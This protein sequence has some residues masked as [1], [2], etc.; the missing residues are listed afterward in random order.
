M[1]LFIRKDRWTTKTLSRIKQLQIWNPNQ[2]RRNYKPLKIAFRYFMEKLR[3]IQIAKKFRTFMEMGGWW[4]CK[5]GSQWLLRMSDVHPVHITTR[6]LRFNLTS[7]TNVRLGLLR[8]LFRSGFHAESL[9]A[10]L[11]AP[12]CST[13][14]AH[15]ILRDSIIPIIYDGDYEL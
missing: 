3:A 4:L 11:I 7:P 5:E 14:P 12:M 6:Y 10:C 2:T 15:L 8:N 1:V 9:F 13:C